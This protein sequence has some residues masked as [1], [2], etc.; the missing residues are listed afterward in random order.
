MLRCLIGSI[1]TSTLLNVVLVALWFSSPTDRIELDDD[2]ALPPDL[3]RLSK[4]VPDA[5]MR[6]G[7]PIPPESA[8][9]T[10]HGAAAV[11]IFARA[12]G[13][14]RRQSAPQSYAWRYAIEIENVGAATVQLLTRHM[15]TTT[16]DG[17]VEEV[18]GAGAG[19]RLP[20]LSPG[21]RYTT[22]GTATLT[23]PLGA[24][25]GSFQFE[26]RG[27]GGAFSA[28]IGRLLLGDRGGRA[29]SVPCAPEA[30]VLARELPPTSVF[31]SY[32]V[33]VGATVEYVPSRSDADLLRHAFQYDVHIHNGRA[34]PVVIHG[35]EWTVLDARGVARTESGAGLGGVEAT[36]KV[37]L[38][39]Q[40]GLKY[41]GMFEL[42]TETGI[43]AARYVVTLED[44]DEEDE[45]TY[46]VLL[47]PM[48][49][50]ADGRPV[51]HIAQNAFA[52][53]AALSEPLRSV[54][55]G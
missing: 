4:P 14:E 15:V 55:A 40:Q 52:A 8:W 20:V 11:A 2:D 31:S 24:M 28:S 37:R 17:R 9:R 38:E 23:A 41:R 6:C 12:E 32:R 10:T 54:P 34:A 45:A 1:A 51:P 18:K 49:V 27:G 26:S 25:H 21:Q 47:A 13:G 53:A 36:G 33:L 7:T 3:I 39:P 16:S 44:E 22:S 5:A 43:A 50:T 30:D 29:Q 19:G 42:P 48:G 35:R 46:D